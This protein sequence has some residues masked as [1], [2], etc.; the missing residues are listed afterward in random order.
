LFSWA[1]TTTKYSFKADDKSPKAPAKPGAREADEAFHYTRSRIIDSIQNRRRGDLPENLLGETD[2]FGNVTLARGVM[3]RDLHETLRHERVHQLL[4]PRRGPLREMR[5]RA[6][7]A[8]YSTSDLWRY[9][10]ESAAETYA[11]RS[12]RQGLRHPLKGDYEISAQNLLRE[13][14]AVGGVGAGGGAAGYEWLTP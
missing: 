8:R 2:R 13:G 6:A 12:L 14:V 10:E 11:T 4:R 1:A 9:F 7:E 3:G 5:A